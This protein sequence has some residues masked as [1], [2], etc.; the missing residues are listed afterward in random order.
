MATSV[1]EFC[2]AIAWTR[3]SREAAAK[4]AR[5]TAESE[6]DGEESANEEERIEECEEDEDERPRSSFSGFSGVVPTQT[7]APAR[8]PKERRRSVR[9][10]A[11]M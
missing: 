4:K 6:E 10:M 2:A 5:R 3:G 8:A 9:L 11:M 1:Q 7:T